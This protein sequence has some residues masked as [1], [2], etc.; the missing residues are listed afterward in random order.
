MMMTM[1]G[2]T[3]EHMSENAEKNIWVP[4]GESEMGASH[5][6]REPP[7]NIN[8]DALQVYHGEYITVESNGSTKSGMTPT[9]VA[10]S[11]G[12]GSNKYIRSD[13]GSKHAVKVINNEAIKLLQSKSY[14]SPAMRSDDLQASVAHIKARFLMWWQEAVKGYHKK[15]PFSENELA[16]LKQNCSQKDYDSVVNNPVVA[17]GCTFL[18]AIAYPDVL[19]ILQYGDGDVLGLYENGKVWELIEPD[20]QNFGNQTLSLCTLSDSSKIQHRVL[21]KRV[22]DEEE[23]TLGEDS[24]ISVKDEMPM[25]I[26]LSTDGIKNSFDDSGEAENGF[27]KIPRDLKTLLERNNFNTKDVKGVLKNELKRI[28]TNGSGDDVTL[29]VLFNKASIKDKESKSNYAQPQH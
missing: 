23:R 14:F 12:H 16:F 11:D 6:R 17:Y 7:Y 21:V 18:A 22:L 19:V 15:Q 4:F 3:K 1:Y 5:S 25:L 27:Y 24:K 9:I 2:K 8:Q 29:G 28:T 13:I 10:V 26:T 20:P